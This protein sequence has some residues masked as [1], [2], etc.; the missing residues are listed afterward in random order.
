[1]IS[2]N[3]GQRAE[4]EE[5]GDLAV[6]RPLEVWG[7][8]EC[9]AS[10]VWGSQAAAAS[11]ASAGLWTHLLKLFQVARD[12]EAWIPSYQVESPNLQLQVVYPS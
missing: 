5:G 9:L 10:V 12:P 1:M 11:P 2:R 7:L 3:P 8:L 6:S 4:A